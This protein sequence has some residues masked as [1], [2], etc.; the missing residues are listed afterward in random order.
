[1][2]SLL[3]ALF[4]FEPGS[5]SPIG[6]AAAALP[7]PPRL[8]RSVLAGVALAH[9]AVLAALLLSTPDAPEAITPP[10]PL[11]V[12]LIVPEVE[13]PQPN[14]VPTPPKPMVN[15]VT[16][17]PVLAV[18][19]PLPL[20]QTVEE[21]PEPAAQPEPVPVAEVQPSPAPVMA[22]APQ[23]ASALPPSPPRAADYLNNPKPPYPALSRRL[24]EEGTVRLSIL[25]NA[26]GSVA[27]L[28]LLKSSGH[29]RLDQS[30]MKT[31]QSSW[32]FEPARQG[33]T[34]VAGW[35]TVPIQFT[36]RS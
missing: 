32:T 29:P 31:V 16:P 34:P 23:V 5:P 7:Y 14:P 9:A 20:P 1:M 4:R 24:G 3:S 33:D 10:R 18:R 28:E 8:S 12:S 17:S 13:V 22:A 35:V 6:H 11:T 21:A 30:A 27:R 36:L 26:D 25:V 2:T 19:R 15:P